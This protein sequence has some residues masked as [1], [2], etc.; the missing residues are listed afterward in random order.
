M[1]KSVVIPYNFVGIFI[2]VAV[3]VMFEGRKK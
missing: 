2:D 1:E 3:F